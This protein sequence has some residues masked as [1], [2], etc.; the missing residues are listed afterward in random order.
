M[1]NPHPRLA[2]ESRGACDVESLSAV[3]GYLVEIADI[4]SHLESSP[5]RTVVAAKGPPDLDN[6]PPNEQGRVWPDKWEILSRGKR[7]K[8]GLLR[9]R[10]FVRDFRTPMAISANHSKLGRAGFGL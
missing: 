10:K 4:P 9:R 1:K 2:P 5:F 8:L 7:P 6:P 3:F